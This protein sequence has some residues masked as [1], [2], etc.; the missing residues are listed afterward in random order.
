VATNTIP[1]GA[2]RGFGSPQVIF[3]H[4]SQMDKL[5]EVLGIDRLEIR[6]R[7]VL[8]AG[9]KTS[10]NQLLEESVGI[11][12]TID[13][14]G[15]MA[16]W[17]ERLAAIDAF[18]AAS[19]DRKRGTGISTITY[20]V[21]LGGKA[22]FLDKAGAY[23]KIEADG[24]I[25]FSV[26]TVEMGQGLI[27]A[28]TQIASEALQVPVERIHIAGD[29]FYR[30]GISGTGEYALFKVQDDR[31]TELIDWTP[32]ED[33]RPGSG[34]N[35]LKVTAKGSQI[36]LY[37]NGELLASINDTSFARGAIGL[38]VEKKGTTDAYVRFDSI[39]VYHAG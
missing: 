6:R 7:N 24:S 21:G 19:E 39:K 33:L 17:R 35:H 36:S 27:T 11:L 3:A 5:A 23:M 18:N 2:F 9:D 20:G 30:F 34:S 31:R 14:A 8:Q 1:C 32:S 16:H 26:G 37:A 4:E 12:E 28:L 22:P 15:E 13:K 10:T 25:A 38:Y 29:G